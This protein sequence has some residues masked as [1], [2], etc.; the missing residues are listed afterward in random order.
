VAAALVSAGARAADGRLVV[1]ETLEGWDATG[2]QTIATA[3][4]ASPGVCAAVFSASSPSLVVVAR[5]SDTNIDASAVVRALMARF[6][7]KGGGKPEL[8][9]A[10][11][12]VGD[13]TEMGAAAREVLGRVHRP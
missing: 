12:L 13:V 1:V 11:G 9:Q 10:G 3:A 8:A 2:L 4:A 7:G 5:A 6:G